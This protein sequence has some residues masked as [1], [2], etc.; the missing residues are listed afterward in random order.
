MFLLAYGLVSSGQQDSTISVLDIPSF[1]GLV[2]GNHPVIQQAE[3]QRDL[4]NAEI[5]MAR[6]S[7]DPII[8]SSWNVKNFKEKEYYNL[9]NTTL[10]IPT[11][12]AVDPKISVDRNTGLFV[13]EQNSIPEENNFYQVNAGVSVPLGR[14]LFIDERRSTLQQAKFFTQLNEA[15]RIKIINKTLLTAVKDY[16]A[17]FLAYQELQLLSQSVGIAQELFNRILIDFDLGEASVV[18]T[19]QAKIVFQTRFAEFEKSKFDYINSQ[20]QLSLHLWS[21]DQIPL[22]LR[23]NVIPDTLADFGQVPSEEDLKELLL[24]AEENHPEI[25]KLDGKMGQLNIERKWNIES[26]K[27]QVDLSYSFIDAPLNP[28]GQSNELSFNDNNKIGVDLYFP[29]FLRKERGKL[30][31]T[32]VKIASNEF[33]TYQRQLQ[34]KNSILSR[35]AEI[36]MTQS[37][38]TQYLEMAQGYNRLLEAELLNLETGESDLFKL[39]IQQ[40]KYIESQRKYLQNLIKFQKNKIE[41]LYDAGVPFLDVTP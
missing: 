24:F 5:R 22:E 29:I 30:Q 31:K 14:G 27:P 17:W 13:D 3:L 37:L 33:E 19:V 39:N 26:L 20:L 34:I 21:E 38:T 41:I 35:F 32:N 40:D 28:W 23:E 18:D 9:F 12:I 15:E 8:S 1:L 2:I 7:F 4:A 11:W 36:Q 6:G 25:R 16:W 10:K